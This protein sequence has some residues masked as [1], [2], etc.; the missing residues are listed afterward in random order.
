MKWNSIIAVAILVLIITFLYGFM[1]G[2][3][4]RNKK[5][6]K[7]LLCNGKIKEEQKDEAE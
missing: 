5:D 4:I 1:V 7:D 6:W 3:D 2:A